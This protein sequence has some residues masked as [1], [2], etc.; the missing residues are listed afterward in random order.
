[1]FTDINLRF[2]SGVL[3]TIRAGANIPEMILQE[4]AGKPIETKSYSIMDGSTMTRFHE[5]IFDS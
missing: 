1:L 3:H 2:G 4:L 5:A